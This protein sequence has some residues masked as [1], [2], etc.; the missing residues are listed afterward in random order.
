MLGKGEFVPEADEFRIFVL[1]NVAVD[2]RQL[3]E[4]RR[5][6]FGLGQNQAVERGQAV[7]EKMRVEVIDQ[8]LVL[9]LGFVVF[10]PGRLHL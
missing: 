10:E 1:Q 9:T 8:V 5:G 3:F 6:F 2:D 7:E 4:E